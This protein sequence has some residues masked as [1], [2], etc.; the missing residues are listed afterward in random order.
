MSCDDKSE[1]TECACGKG[2][3][4][5]VVEMDDWN[6]I[7]NHTDIHCPRC[8]KKATQDAEARERKEALKEALYEEAQ[9]LAEKR[10]LEQWLALYTGL[11]TKEAWQRHTGGSGYPA[12][13]TFYK[14]VKDAGSLTEYMRWRFLS[15]FE[16]A[17]R[18]MAV[19]DEDIQKLLSQREQFV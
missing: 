1:T 2:T 17:L 15:D 10:Y 18:K 11:A 3:T 8:L 6:R 7:R 14:H 13:G 4:T 9:K 5:F 12:L 16:D 19:N